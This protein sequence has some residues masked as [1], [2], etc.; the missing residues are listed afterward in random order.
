MKKL[1]ECERCGVITKAS[2]HL[3]HPNELA[4]K[5]DYCGTARESGH[6]CPQM[7]LSLSYVCGSCGRP[8]EQAGLLCQPL[9]LGR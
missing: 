6:L 5:H 1:Y 8:A 9:L 3:C 4:D 7:R 2:K